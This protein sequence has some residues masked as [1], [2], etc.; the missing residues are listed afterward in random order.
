MSIEEA[1]PT[2]KS[3]AP[4]LKGFKLKNFKRR[5]SLVVGLLVII[6]LIASAVSSALPL[7]ARVLTLHPSDFA[8]GFTEEGTIVP[9][10]EEPIFNSVEGKLE[11][12]WVQ[13]GD[14]VKKDQVLFE[15]STSD[16]NY[17]LESLKAQ[18]VSLEGQRLQNYKSPYIALVAQQELIIEQAEKD[19]QAQEENLS[20]MKTL[21]EAQAVSLTQYEEAQRDSEKAQSVL[22]Q[23]KKGLQ[24]LYEQ[25]KAAPGTEM[26]YT[27][28]KNALQAQMS[29]LQDKINKSKVLAP[30]DGI[31]K[32]I[33]LKEG[34]FIPLGQQL[35]SVI[36]DQGYKIESYVLA[37]DVLD[38]KVGSDVA[39]TQDTSGGKKTL[40]GQVIAVDPSAVERISPLGLKEN[41]V[42]VTLLLEKNSA[43]VLGSSVDLRFTILKVPNKYM[44][45]KTILFPYQKGYAVWLVKEGKAKIQS[46]QKGLENEHDVVI[47]Q[48]LSDGD[49][50]LLDL[51]LKNLKE[52]KRIKTKTE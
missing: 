13:N 50:V 7:E 10:Q 2:L 24:L 25:Q 21:Y 28:Q 16:L 47:E 20:R 19:K 46:V 34:T 15:M 43:V 36:Q 1:M 35:M 40:S 8:K 49:T 18:L 14:K 27:G 22:E 30:Q 32:D 12:L 51:D 44:I 11:S 42:K 48:G 37:R 5:K 38:L 29:Q 3:E 39:I 6:V 9:A 23:Q 26:Y 41:R 52:G 17:Q 33:S 45:P 4:K 31:I